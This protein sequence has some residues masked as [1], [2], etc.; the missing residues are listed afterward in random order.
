[1]TSVEWP[2]PV[3]TFRVPVADTTVAHSATRT[4]KTG[5]LRVIMLPEKQPIAEK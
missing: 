2:R 3:K 5:I 1:M 4:N